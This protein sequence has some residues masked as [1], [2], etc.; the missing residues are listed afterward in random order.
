MNPLFEKSVYQNRRE[1]LTQLVGH[2]IAV[3]LGNHEAVDN[4]TSIA[5]FANT[6]TTTIACPQPTGIVV[7]SITATGFTVNWTPAGDETQWT[8]AYRV[9]TASTWT[10]VTVTSHPY[11]ITGLTGST[12]YNV[13]VK[14]NC[15]STEESQW[16]DY[17]DPIVTQTP[18]CPT[19]TDVTIYN[20]T[21]HTADISWSQSDNTVTAWRLS[22]RKL[23]QSWDT[24]DVNTNSYTFTGLE[25]TSRYV[26][27]VY[28]NCGGNNYSTAAV[29]SFTTLEDQ[30]TTGIVDY[31]EQ[32]ITVYPN[33]TDGKIMVQNS[34]SLIQDVEV[35]DAFGKMLFAN[36]VNDNTATLDMT[37]YAAGMYFARISTSEG[38]ITKRFIKK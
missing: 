24:V 16:T 29:T 34:H 32:I 18:P 2:G 19:P 10:E 1:K 8:V 22:Y 38:V 20:L 3:F 11:A 4:T 6:F 35:Y 12:T 9:N 27:R 5:S 7:S 36:K 17:N 37:A 31:L 28:A 26:V 13:R 15:S 33:P 14:A 23:G 30:D 21:A 25:A